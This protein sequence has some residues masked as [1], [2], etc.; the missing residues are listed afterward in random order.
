MLF[1]K[2]Q[3]TPENLSSRYINE[4][5]AAMVP[6]VPNSKKQESQELCELLRQTFNSKNQTR[7]EIGFSR[8]SQRIPKAHSNRCYN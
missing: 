3:K 5:E 4:S 2:I 6:Y 7:S 8:S 1:E